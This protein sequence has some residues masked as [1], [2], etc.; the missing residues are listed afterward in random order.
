MNTRKL[1]N[2]AGTA[3]LAV[4]LYIGSVAPVAAAPSAQGGI[5]PIQAHPF[6]CY[7]NGQWYPVGTKLGA[8]PLF[9][10]QCELVWETGPL[11]HPDLQAVWKIYPRQ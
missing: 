2:I 9:Y 11:G 4:G 3:L 5:T 8:G 1:R 7:Y 10:R 6:E